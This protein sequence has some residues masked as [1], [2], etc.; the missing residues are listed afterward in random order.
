MMYFCILV[1]TLNLIPLK[2]ADPAIDLAIVAALV[3][4][5]ED[6]FIAK[7]ICFAGEI[8]LTGEIRS[9]KNIEARIKE[10]NRLGFEQIITSANNLKGIDTKRFDIDIK[11]LKKIEELIE[12]FF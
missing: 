9:V 7:N 4:S 8:S 11:G 2:I 5:L 10:A 6:T 1:Q 12:Y 3:S